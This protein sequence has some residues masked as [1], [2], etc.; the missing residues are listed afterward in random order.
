MCLVF[1]HPSAF[2]IYEN[3]ELRIKNDELTCLVFIHP[4]A[5][6][7]YENEELRIKN[8]ELEK[9]EHSSFCVLHSTFMKTKS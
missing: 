6:Y 5:F 8:E 4:S 2:Y 3:E 9:R 1:I 7:I